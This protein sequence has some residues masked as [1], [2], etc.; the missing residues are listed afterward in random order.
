[1]KAGDKV[2]VIEGTSA[3]V[4]SRWIGTIKTIHLVLDDSYFSFLL[5]DE[6]GLTLHGN[7]IPASS[8]LLEL[9]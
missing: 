8:L 7:G 4:I 9:F 3:L 5:V 6:K 1:M 2:L